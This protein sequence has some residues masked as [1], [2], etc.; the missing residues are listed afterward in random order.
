MRPAPQ[1]VF[2]GS[3]GRLLREAL[4][5]GRGF[6]PRTDRDAQHQDRAASRCQAHNT[7]RLRPLT[8]LAA[9]VV[10]LADLFDDAG[11]EAQRVLGTAPAPGARIVVES[12]QL[13]AIARQF[14][15]DWRPSSPSD[16][17]VLERPGKLMPREPV[18][19]VLKEALAGLGAPDDADIDLPGFSPPL[20]PQEADPHA[21]VEQLDYDAGTGKF[22]GMLAIAADGMSMLRVR[23]SGTVQPMV[24]VPVPA[25]K[26]LPG[27]VIRADDLQ[28]VRV[29]T[30][31][32]RGEV[33]RVAE[34]AVGVAPRRQMTPGQPMPL[35]DLAHL[36][37]IRKGAQIGMVL[38]TPG[39]T[40]LA[41]GIALEP[42]GIGDRIQVLNP[43]SRAVVEAVVIAA[44]RVRVAPGSTPLLQSAARPQ[45]F[46]A[47][48]FVRTSVP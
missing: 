34:Q 16:R 18:M 23:L 47:N 30:G 2:V 31:L 36:A 24:E 14:G 10:R 3:L 42:G 6:P 35:G 7:R 28:M 40:L 15:V 4:H 19:A 8:S 37:A 26:L 22:T 38:E 33:A 29:R 5:K 43:V 32:I 13:A 11:A 41:Q 1:S 25:H 46:G 48:A 12:A 21:V 27:A 20:V 45:Q 44:D 39:L 9:P 17:A